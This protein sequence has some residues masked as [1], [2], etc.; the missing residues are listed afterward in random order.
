MRV[1]VTG[2]SGLVG[3]AIQEIN[4]DWTYISS[5]DCNLLDN[6]AFTQYLKNNPPFDF[7]IHLAANVGGLFKNQAQK[8]K[9]FQDNLRINL[10][11]IENCF[12]A[13][14]PRMICCLSTCVFPDKLNEKNNTNI[15]QLSNNT[16]YNMNEDD[17]HSGEPHES[18]YGYA[19][20][21]R[22]IDIHCKLI[23]NNSNFFYQCIIPTNIYGP[24]DQFSNPQNAHVIPA[25]ITKASIIQKNKGDT[26]KIY[27]SG[28]PIRQF[29]YSRDLA[30]I[31]NHLVKNDIRIQ[32]L[33]CAPDNGDERSIIHIANLIAENFNIPYV[34]PEEI[35]PCNNDGQQSK[36]CSNKLLKSILPNFTFTPL[37]DGIRQTCN[38]YKVVYNHINNI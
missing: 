28:L 15:K 17:L 6:N 37:K 26:L 19:Y 38:W 16:L 4:P 21:K 1:L 36:T 34:I 27:G 24:Y 12:N 11:V 2:G 9:M 22:I 5:S 32:K 31:I 33:I 35:N 3:L 18:N 25:L 7:V 30:K 20:A 23:N 14:I 8:I 10:N 29:I 13:N